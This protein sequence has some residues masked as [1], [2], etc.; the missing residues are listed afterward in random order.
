MSVR[1]AFAVAA[2]LEPE[3]LLVD[4]VLAVG[5][6]EFQRRASGG[7]RTSSQSGARCSSS[8][9]TCRRW[10]SSATGRSSS[11]EGS[12]VLDGPSAE[13]V[14][15]YLQSRAGSGSTRFWTRSRRGP[16]DDLVRFARRASIQDGAVI[17]LSRR[18]RVRSASRSLSQ[19]C[20]TTGRVFP[21]IKVYDAQGNVVFNA[22]DTSARWLES[23]PARRL[24]V[25]R[26]DPGQPPERGAD[27]GRRRR[28][29]DRHAQAAPARRLERRGRLP[30]PGSRRG[31]LCEGTLRGTAP[32]RGASTSRMDDSRELIAHGHGRAA[33]RGARRHA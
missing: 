8:R 5:D 24:R 28:L 12:V 4:E 22:L 14:A 11:T 32:R 21:K 27:H 19:S 20:G 30:R 29:L 33:R 10:R 26:V 1:L 9:T 23:V 25:D 7:W 3:I 15:Q 17:E 16:G 2:H 18:A 31:R 6:A 13:V